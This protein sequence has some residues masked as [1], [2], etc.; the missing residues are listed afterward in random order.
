MTTETTTADQ[1]TT[2]MTTTD[3]TIAEVHELART[4]RLDA[5]SHTEPP[6]ALFPRGTRRPAWYCHAGHPHHG[7]FDA[8]ACN[9]VEARRRLEL[10]EL[11]GIARPVEHRYAGSG[12][13]FYVVEC[14]ACLAGLNSGH[15]YGGDGRELELARE[16]A[17]RHNLETHGYHE[18]EL[19][20]EATS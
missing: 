3:Q 12:R 10:R 20:L 11:G 2:T 5:G 9:R 17:A 16:L 14:P 8:A 18:D 13:V 7:K 6:S 1:E 19:E 15:H 4:M